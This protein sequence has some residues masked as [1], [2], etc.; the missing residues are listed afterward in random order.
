MLRSFGRAFKSS[1][2]SDQCQGY[3][4]IDAYVVNNLMKSKDYIEEE[5]KYRQMKD[6]LERNGYSR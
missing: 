3:S 4:K 2:T 6:V 5:T 1:V